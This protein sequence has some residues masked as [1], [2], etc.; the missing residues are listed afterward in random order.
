M[1]TSQY[2][3][4]GTQGAITQ[5]YHFSGWGLEL[6]FFG[7]ILGALMATTTTIALPCP[8]PI[9]GKVKS[10][11]NYCGL[12][13]L[14]LFSLQLLCDTGRKFIGQKHGRGIVGGDYS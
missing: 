1:K 10:S 5:N 3:C 11:C 4:L 6:T 2:T 8:T 9:Q 7:S 13:S 14:V 12:F